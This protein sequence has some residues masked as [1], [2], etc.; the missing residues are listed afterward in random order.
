MLGLHI[1]ETVGLDKV[2]HLN[3]VL[4]TRTR[5][6]RSLFAYGFPTPPTKTVEQSSSR[7]RREPAIENERL[8][9]EH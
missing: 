2:M 1:R 8:A 6:G 7:F 5:T 9:M 4:S 3:V